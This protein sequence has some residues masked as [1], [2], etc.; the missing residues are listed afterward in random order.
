MF[1][2]LR[3]AVYALVGYA[4]Y[5]FFTDVIKGMPEQKPARAAGG[6]GGKG[7]GGRA[8]GRAATGGSRAR[9]GGAA[10]MT[11][12]A[13]SGRVEETQGTDGGSVR[14]RVGRGVV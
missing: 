8:G 2:V 3:L 5:H 11:G 7:R 9:S 12:Q 4:A 13:K 10:R 14:H 6:T 1:K